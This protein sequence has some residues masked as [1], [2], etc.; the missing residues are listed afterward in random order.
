MVMTIMKPQCV[1]SGDVF[2]LDVVGRIVVMCL[3]PALLY[4]FLSGFL[5]INWANSLLL[6]H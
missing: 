1:L 2:P 5:K 6:N 3:R 4:Q